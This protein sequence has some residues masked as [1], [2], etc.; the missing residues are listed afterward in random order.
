[1]VIGKIAEIY[2]IL[3]VHMFSIRW[4]WSVAVDACVVDLES[5]SLPQLSTEYSRFMGVMGNKSTTDP[6]NCI[7]F[8]RTT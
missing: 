1:M 5:I 2:Q 6:Q 4:R 8:I 7:L 3:E